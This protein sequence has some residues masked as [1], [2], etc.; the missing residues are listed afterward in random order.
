MLGTT[1]EQGRVVGLLRTD[2]RPIG[3]ARLTRELSIDHRI[4]IKSVT[5][6][7]TGKVR[8]LT[9]PQNCLSTDTFGNRNDLFAK[10]VTY[11]RSRSSAI[12]RLGV[13]MSGNN[14]IISIRIRRPIC[15]A[16]A[17]RLCVQSHRS[18][19][20]F[21]GEVTSGRTTVLSSLANNIRLRALTYGSRRA[22][23]HVGVRLR[24]TKVLCSKWTA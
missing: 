16:L 11:R 5:L 2:S 17:K 1:R 6:V 15:N 24:R 14:R 18:I 4:V 22:F 19:V 8:V 7:H 13:V 23:L 12:A 21:V 9:A 20:S 3:T 10:G